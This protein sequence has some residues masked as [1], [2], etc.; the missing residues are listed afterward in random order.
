MPVLLWIATSRFAVL[1]MTVCILSLRG[2]LATKQS[3]DAGAALD[4]HV[5]LRG[6]RDD[7]EPRWRNSGLISNDAFKQIRPVRVH[8]LDQGKLFTS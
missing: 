5:P 8:R 3:S 7:G 2:A 6:P 1:A 4:R